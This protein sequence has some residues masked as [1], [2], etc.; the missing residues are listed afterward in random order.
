MA[1]GNMKK[2]ELVD[3]VKT[4]SAKLTKL[5]KWKSSNDVFGHIKKANTNYIFEFFCYVKVLIDFKA[6]Y[7]INYIDG[8]NKFPRAPALKQGHSYFTIISKKKA[9]KSYQVCAGIRI[10]STLFLLSEHPDISFLDINAGDNPTE[11]DVFIIMDAKHRVNGSSLTK[12]E[13]KVF[14]DTIVNLAVQNSKNEPIEFDR[15]K[16]LKGNC[17]ITNGLEYKELFDY[18]KRK[19]IIQI[20][21]FDLKGNF[22]AY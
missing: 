4:Y 1:D 10:E 15:M 3:K 19:E 12:P 17:L 18:C 14:A 8:K 5:S 22:D 16:S 21:N 2:R 20:V 9:G 7:E 13:I 11:K 6:N